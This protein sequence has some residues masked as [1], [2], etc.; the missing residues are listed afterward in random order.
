[1]PLATVPNPSKA[2]L[3]VIFIS[4]KFSNIAIITEFCENSYY[5]KSLF[6][7]KKKKRIRRF[8][9]LKI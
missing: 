4:S 2:I 6:Q 1:T 5:S 3:T 7:Y 9:L 8:A